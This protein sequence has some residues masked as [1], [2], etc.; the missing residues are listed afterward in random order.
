[1]VAPGGPLVPQDTPSARTA[2]GTKGNG[3]F[4]AVL[5]ASYRQT[6]AASGQ[7]QL[8]T[9]SEEEEVDLAERPTQSLLEDASGGY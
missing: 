5:A 9:A 4:R 2:E 6:W 3:R 7:S 8:K 1:M